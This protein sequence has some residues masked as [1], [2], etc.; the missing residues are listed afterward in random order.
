VSIKKYIEELKKRNVI[1]AA[2]AYLVIAWLIIQVASIVL[3]T[4]DA[5]TYIL[6]T[7]L[8]VLGVGFPI[9]ILF[10][11]TYDITEKGLVKTS[12]KATDDVSKLKTKNRLNVV[13]ISGLSLTILLLLFNLNDKLDSQEL[14]KIPNTDK[15]TIAVLAFEDMSP[16]KDQEYFSDGMAAELTSLL[17]K[18]KDITVIDRRS[19]FSFKGENATI[20]KIGAELNATHVIDGSVRKY[21]NKVRIDIQL[22]SVID[23]STISSNTFDRDIADVLEMQN[24]IAFKVRDQLRLNLLSNI[25]TKTNVDPKAYD[26][27][28]Q[29]DYLFFRHDDDFI[30]DAISLLRKSIEIDTTNPHTYTLLSRALFTAAVNYQS[31]P[32]TEAITE[33]RLMAQKAIK[34]DENS[35]SAYAM[36]A[37]LS[38]TLDLDFEAA[39]K[40]IN[41]AYEANPNEAFVLASM[42]LIQGYSGNLDNLEENYKRII[43]ISPKES[44]YYRNIGIGYYWKGELDKSIE[45]LLKF[46]NLNPGAAIGNSLLTRVYL[47]KGDLDS[48]LKHAEKETNE[49]WGLMAKSIVFYSLGRIEESNEAIESFKSMMGEDALG[50]IAEIYAFRNDSESTLKYLNDAYEMNPADLVEVINYPALKVVYEDPRWKELL[51]KMNLPENHRLLKIFK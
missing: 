21:E 1:K 22:I 6:K 38:L 24:E 37:K 12:N 5:P 9:W 29:A 18:M 13:I 32:Y 50:N 47:E 14:V 42:Q 17:S 4:F 20:S 27:Y 44:R 33:S 2:L 16:L 35:A 8:L 34:I 28:M 19:S 39:N 10:S 36:L 23:G 31:I 11:W 41:K 7:I 26:L 48:A 45:N 43:E 49:F 15:I 51:L 46:N 25:E 30:I 40:F 3:P